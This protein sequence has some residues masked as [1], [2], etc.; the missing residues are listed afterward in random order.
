MLIARLT[1]RESAA[2]TDPSEVS[3]HP[4]APL[5]SALLNWQ[6]WSRE[7]FP[8]LPFY[9]EYCS[10]RGAMCARTVDASLTII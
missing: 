2:P 1:R 5:G 10:S 8:E 6:C 7:M 9:Q 3:G 4:V